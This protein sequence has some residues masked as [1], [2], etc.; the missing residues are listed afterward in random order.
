M[1]NVKNLRVVEN[2][3]KS[4][5]AIFKWDPVNISLKKMRGYFTGFEVLL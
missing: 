5:E 2:T 1:E 4:N 3:I